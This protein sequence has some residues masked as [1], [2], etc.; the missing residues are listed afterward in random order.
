MQVYLIKHLDN[1]S[2][3]GVNPGGLGVSKPPDFGLGVVKY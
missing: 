3:I 1:M 2:S